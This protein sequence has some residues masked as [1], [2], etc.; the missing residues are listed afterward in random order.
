[1]VR[2][3]SATTGSSSVSPSTESSSALT[4][5]SSLTSASHYRLD[6]EGRLVTVERPP[7]SSWQGMSLDSAISTPDKRT[8]PSH[9]GRLSSLAS[10]F[11]LAKAKEVPLVDVPKEAARPKTSKTVRL[12]KEP[13]DIYRWR[14]V[15]TP[16]SKGPSLDSALTHWIYVE[17]TKDSAD[18]QPWHTSLIWSVSSSSLIHT[19]SGSTYRL[20]GPPHMEKQWPKAM[21]DA[22]YD[23]FPRREWIVLMAQ[24]ARRQGYFNEEK[25]LS[26]KD[27]QGTGR[28]DVP[29][30]HRQ[31]KTEGKGVVN[32]PAVNSCQSSKQSKRTNFKIGEGEEVNGEQSAMSSQCPSGPATLFCKGQLDT[33]ELIAPQSTQAGKVAVEAIEN[34]TLARSV[35]A[36]DDESR[37]AAI[38]EPIPGSSTTAPSEMPTVVASTS[39][40]GKSNLDAL[41]ADVPQPNKPKRT[42]NTSSQKRH[43]KSRTLLKELAG[44]RRSKLGILAVVDDAIQESMC[45]DPEEDTEPR[46]EGETRRQ[47]RSRMRASTSSSDS[48]TV[49]TL[50]KVAGE[51]EKE[52][53]RSRQ[54]LKRRRICSGDDEV[55]EEGNCAETTI[56]AS[57]TEERKTTPQQR[58]RSKGVG[59]WWQVSNGE[60]DG[61]PPKRRAAVRSRSAIAAAAA[62]QEAA[63]ALTDLA[64]GEGGTVSSEEELDSEDE[65]V[66]EGILAAKKEQASDTE[67]DDPRQLGEKRAETADKSVV[68]LQEDKIV[69]GELQGTRSALTGTDEAEAGARDS[70]KLCEEEVHLKLEEDVDNFGD[71]ESQA[72]PGVSLTDS[73]LSSPPLSSSTSSSP[74]TSSEAAVNVNAQVVGEDMRLFENTRTSITLPKS[75]DRGYAL[76][77]AMLLNGSTSNESDF[78]MSDYVAIASD[79]EDTT[80]TYASACKRRF[81][82]SLVVTH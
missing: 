5:V 74:S 31:K 50:G 28:N 27:V 81:R 40:T 12:M 15:L 14:P 57:E 65:Y 67:E 48:N 73:P 76:P 64:G 18:G 72:T 11:E 22:F 59:K 62:D 41:V 3:I 58:R 61:Q 1:M 55:A 52:S 26:M 45:W 46:L 68:G 25:N 7:S 37:I 70:E 20:V 69:G 80:A 32:D 34:S 17:G 24:E 39:T 78:N 29:E 63:R 19:R 43:A 36:K 9:A 4:P 47:T 21:C 66:G 51:E 16:C 35:A 53:T 42:A 10:P 38:A 8:L 49:K 44:L 33:A 60:D 13:I 2:H 79:E 82:H 54:S 75:A 30:H 23:G 6:E 56:G 71:T 77:N